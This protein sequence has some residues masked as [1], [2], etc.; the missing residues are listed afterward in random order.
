MNFKHVVP[1]PRCWQMGIKSMG[2]SD[3]FQIAA[4]RPL[5]V[6]WVP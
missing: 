1:G 6:R 3:E 5:T 4:Y 2:K